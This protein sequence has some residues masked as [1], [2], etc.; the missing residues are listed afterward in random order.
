MELKA[1]GLEGMAAVLL[2]YALLPFATAAS[3]LSVGSLREDF[4]ILR[5][6]LEQAHGGIYR[7]SPKAEMDRRY[8]RGVIPDYPVTYTIKELL[9]RKDKEMD[10]AV[11]LA[12]APAAPR[13][14]STHAQPGRSTRISTPQGRQSRRRL[15]RRVVKTRIIRTQV[16]MGARVR[17]ISGAL[18]N[19]VPV[20][21]IIAEQAD[22][23]HQ[24]GGIRRFHEV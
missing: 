2:M 20:H 22:K 10:I 9:G 8:D 18:G 16:M 17:S 21:P 12:R 1:A 5:L 15:P 13:A 4:Q 23:F 19:V 3:E 7:Y 6:A 24:G 14:R 11:A